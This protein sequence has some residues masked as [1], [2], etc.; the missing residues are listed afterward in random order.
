MPPPIT[1]TITAPAGNVIGPAS[2]SLAAAAASC[3]GD[4]TLT[5]S[6]SGPTTP[7]NTKTGANAIYTVGNGQGFDIDLA[8]RTALSLVASVVAVD[9][10]GRQASATLSFTVRPRGLPARLGS[11]VPKFVP[12]IDHCV[13]CA[14]S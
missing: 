12:V 2:I 14:H 9:T 6:V 5:W 10:A 1:A 13:R 8:G 11:I 7:A 3:V 4:C